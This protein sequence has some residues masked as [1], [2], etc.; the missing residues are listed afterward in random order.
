VF[1]GTLALAQ[2]GDAGGIG[3]WVHV[4]GFAA[5]IVLQFFF[6]RRSR[7][8]RPPSRDEYGVEGAWVSPRHWRQDA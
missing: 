4:G 8:Q 5:G 7:D 6:V 2:P 3:W 1:S